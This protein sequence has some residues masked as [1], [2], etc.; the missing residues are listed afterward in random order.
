MKSDNWLYEIKP[1]GKFIDLNLKEIWRYRDLLIL[2]V[3]RDI[4]TVYKQTVLGPLWFLIQ[5]LFTGVI[6]TLVFNKLGGI[7][8]YGVPSFLFNLSGITLWSYFKE[9]LS[10]TSKT[11]LTNSS[12]FGKVY[13]PRVIAPASK[14]LSGLL[15]YVIQLGIFFVFYLF[16][17]WNGED[18]QFGPY[19]YLLPIPVFS[20][21]MLGLGVGMI[22]SSLTTKYRDL[23]ILIDFGIQLLMYISAVMYSLQFASEELG[24][25][26]W[27]VTYNPLAQLIEL[28]R[29][30]LLDVGQDSLWQLLIAVVVSIATLFVGL[31]I[32]NRTEKTFIDTV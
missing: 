7:N 19:W 13:F 28:Y 30:M 24:E 20:V 21:A 1:K 26:A 32:F 8:T 3:K 5:P 2:F 15:K 17:L 16:F 22:L 6:F 9:S 11:F 14:V 29:N 31:V 12:L 18:L 10:T 27:V 25:Y 4:V 23:S